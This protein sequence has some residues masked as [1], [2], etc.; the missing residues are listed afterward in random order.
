MKKH[1]L[2][3]I[4]AV[5]VLCLAYTG[6]DSNAE[7]VAELQTEST[8][9]QDYESLYRQ[10]TDEIYQ[11]LFTFNADED[12]TAFG[13]L[14]EVVYRVE[15][16]TD[17]L[18]SVGY[19]YRD[20]S[21]DGVPELLIGAIDVQKKTYTGADLYAVYT[22][23]DNKPKLI[24]S[25]FARSHYRL[26]EEGLFY[27][28]SS[29]AAESGFGFFILNHEGTE[30]I[31]KD[32]YFT[33]LNEVNESAIDYYHNQTGRWEKEASEKMDISEDAFWNLQEK[34]KVQS[35]E[36]TPFSNYFKYAL[37]LE[38][39]EKGV[40]EQTNTEVEKVVLHEGEFASE[41][42]L[43][44]REPVRMLNVYS[45]SLEEVSEDGEA[46]YTAEE[47]YTRTKL[48]PDE[49]ITIKM[50]LP[51]LFP[52]CGISYEDASGVHKL[53]VYESSRDGL[54]YLDNASF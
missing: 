23:Q 9:K 35:V 13:G 22:L 34:S 12:G 50:E 36:M 1:T 30:L 29:G 53:A 15:E 43:L 6:C 42:T 26:D 45:L 16:R 54:V 40:T 2:A 17:A 21:G 18:K 24:V 47:V 32:F 28:G 46:N 51:E 14:S 4:F 38:K 3:K 11:Y 7:S 20:I 19:C 44:C 41:Y 37:R 33:A 5:T 31:C 49:E 27:T 48:L 25:S 52:I 8:E 10:V 39:S